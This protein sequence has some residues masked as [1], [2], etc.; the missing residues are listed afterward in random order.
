LPLGTGAVPA[1]SGPSMMMVSDSCMSDP[2]SCCGEGVPRGSLEPMTY[3]RRRYHQQRWC[4]SHGSSRW[5][6]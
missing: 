1:L 4:A 3:L 6:C 5:S 2:S